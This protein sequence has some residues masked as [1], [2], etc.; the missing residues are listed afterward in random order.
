MRRLPSPARPGGSMDIEGKGGVD[1]RWRRWP[2]AGSG[3]CLGGQGG[4]SCFARP[5]L[6][7]QRRGRPARGCRVRAGGREAIRRGRGGGGRRLRQLGR[8]DICLNAAAWGGRRCSPA[9]ARSSL[10]ISSALVVGINLA[11]TFDVIRWAAS[12]PGHNE[13]NDDG[14]RG[15]VINVASMR[16]TRGRSARRPTRHPREGSSG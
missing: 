7:Q 2:R 4:V 12:L 15:V 9:M 16:P 8:I 14:E 3:Q 5:A 1:H 6:V 10:S 11:G 13:P